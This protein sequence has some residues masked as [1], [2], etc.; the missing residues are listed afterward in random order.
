MI[1]ISGHTD[2]RKMTT[3]G[4]PA[5]CGRFI[6]FDTPADLQSL[7]QDGALSDI[8]PIGGGS[9][10]LFATGSYQGT[11]VHCSCSDI[12]VGAPDAGG[13]V[14]V[15]AAAGCVLD[16]LCALTAAHGLWGIEN[17]SG[18]PGEIGGAAVQNVGAYGIEFRDTVIAVECFDTATGKCLTLANADC[19]YGYRD[20]I[21]KHRAGQQPLIVTA[22][23]L[24]LSTHPAPRL[25]YAAIAER[26]ATTDPS[27]LTPSM[28]RQTVIGLRD[29]KLPD[30]KHTGSAGSFFKNPIVSESEY[31]LI[32]QSSNK[33][34][35]G[36]VLPDN[37]V[38]LSAAWLI[39]NAGCKGLSHGGAALWQS[40]P[41]V[42][43]NATG[44]ATGSD[45][46]SLERDVIRAVA[47]KFGITLEPEVVHI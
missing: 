37:T 18:I 6:E 28:L 15:R 12:T 42:I 19:A 9:N 36:H 26:F 34:V 4:L 41:L 30:P 45:V 44:H 40:Q 39:D 5:E 46:V 7:Y 47:S 13:Y 1:H 33:P 10:L 16:H 31:L 17:L 23:T 27:E 35:P 3:F 14:D 24:R 20:S 43:V 11:V 25:G 29:S 21:F 8:L 22:V 32:Q 2:I 38:K